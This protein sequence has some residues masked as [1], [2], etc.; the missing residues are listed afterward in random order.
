M[1]NR[2][3][4]GAIALSASVTLLGCKDSPEK[5][6]QEQF[7][8]RNFN[9]INFVFNYIITKFKILKCLFRIFIF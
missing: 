2:L 1:M 3:A 6:V 7:H 8:K 5:Q 9:L 4:V